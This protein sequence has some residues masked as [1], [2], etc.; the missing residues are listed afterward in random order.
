M[1]EREI[2]FGH[3]ISQAPVLV[4]FPNP[5]KSIWATMFLTRSAA[6]TCPCGNKAYCETFAPTNNI[7]EEFLQVATQAPQPIQVAASI[8][9]SAACFEIG[10]A[11][12]S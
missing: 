10:V 7:A 3:S 12:A 11:L 2:P 9:S 5:S 4:Q 6:S 8:A 1:F